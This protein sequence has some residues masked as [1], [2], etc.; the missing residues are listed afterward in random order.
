M[1][2]IKTELETEKISTKIKIRT[3][4]NRSQN[5][6]QAKKEEKELKEQDSKEFIL[7]NSI[8]IEPLE[9]QANLDSVWINN[10][11]IRSHSVND[12][13]NGQHNEQCLS[14]Q[15]SYSQPSYSHPYHPE[16]CLCPK[17]FS[18]SS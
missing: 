6:D 13:Q 16:I 5:R 10:P 1:E 7:S 15:S 11:S 17:L 18:N 3:R 12:F 2:K 4:S 14:F 9:N 8:S